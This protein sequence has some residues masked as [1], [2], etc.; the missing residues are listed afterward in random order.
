M[1]KLYS[2]SSPQESAKALA[3][4]IAAQIRRIL[5]VKAHAGLALSGGKSP[6]VFLQELSQMPLE[7]GKCRISLVDERV[8][9]LTDPENNALLMHMYFLQNKA[10]V[11]PFAP[12]VLDA[13]VGTEELLKHAMASYIQPDLAVLGMGKDGHTA[14]LFACAPEYENALKSQEPIIATTPTSAPF[15]RLSMSLNA[16]E[17][18]QM[19]YLLI[20]GDQ[21]KAVFERACLALEPSLP[22]S[23]ILHSQKVVCHVYCA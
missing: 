20:S 21:K 17:S 11:A 4:E 23:Y 6:I 22:I 3:I 7:W 9:P 19:L 16:L 12:L 2:F 10:Q 1:F 14:S 5:S 8:L 13:S 18:C 15:K